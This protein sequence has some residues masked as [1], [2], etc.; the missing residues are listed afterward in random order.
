MILQNGSVQA[1]GARDEL[2]PLVM[3]RKPS[4]TSGPPMLDA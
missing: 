3:G 1:F 2:I 4:G